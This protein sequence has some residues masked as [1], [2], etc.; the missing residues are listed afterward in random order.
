MQNLTSTCYGRKVKWCGSAA[1]WLFDV[2]QSRRWEKEIVLWHKLHAQMPEHPQNGQFNCVATSNIVRLV[3]CK[4]LWL[5]SALTINSLIE[6]FIDFLLLRRR[7][8][9]LLLH[10]A[11][12]HHR[13]FQ[14]S[15]N[16]KFHI[17][18]LFVIIMQHFIATFRLLHLFIYYIWLRPGKWFVVMLHIHSFLRL[19]NHFIVY[20]NQLYN[21]KKH[22]KIK[23]KLQKYKKRKWKIIN[24]CKC[25]IYVCPHK[26]M[27]SVN[28]N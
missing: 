3:A 22:Y 18:Y 20:K 17:N 19:F 26:S 1:K 16:H 6:F 12:S 4:W 9:P 24:K 28:Y 23:K 27:Q 15:I 10:F 8:M 13:P 7:C 2:A 25:K 5:T 14:Q 21:N 11:P